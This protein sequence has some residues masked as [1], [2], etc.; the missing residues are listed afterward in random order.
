MKI[1][2]SEQMLTW[3]WDSTEIKIELSDIIHADSIIRIFSY[4]RKEWPCY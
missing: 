3:E 2:Y 4:I 1:D